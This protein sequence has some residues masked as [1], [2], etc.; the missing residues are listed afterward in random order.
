MYV[1]YKIINLE[2]ISFFLLLTLDLVLALVLDLSLA[3]SEFSNDPE[4]TIESE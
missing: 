4:Q 2:E 3:L 1:Y